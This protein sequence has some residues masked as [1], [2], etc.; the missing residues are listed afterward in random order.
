MAPPKL[1]SRWAAGRRCECQLY[2]LLLHGTQRGSHIRKALG[3]A[4]RAKGLTAVAIR[5]AGHTQ[6]TPGTVTVLAVGP[7]PAKT[8]DSITGH[9]KLL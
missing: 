8:V 3:D 1:P 9:L 4:A 7:G 2:N 6:V 5:D